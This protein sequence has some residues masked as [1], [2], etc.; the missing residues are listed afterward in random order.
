MKGFRHSRAMMLVAVA[1]LMPATGCASAGARHAMTPGGGRSPGAPGVT[2][3]IAHHAPATPEVA[4]EI[5]A[6]RKDGAA[7]REAVDA[8]T[9]MLVAN[10]APE[11]RA[12]RV[13]PA[14]VRHAR[15]QRIDPVLVVAIIGV[16]NP[17]LDLDAKSPHG[18]AV[19]VMQVWKGWKKEIHDCGG[20]DLTDP[21]VNVCFGTRVLRMALDD[22]RTLAGA[23]HRY[24]GCTHGARC[25]RYV[26]AVY[27]RAGRALLEGGSGGDLETA[28]SNA[29]PE[30]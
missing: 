16:E 15:E 10:G 25:D 27:Q 22:T 7:A 13:A 29:T 3:V 8:V 6:E 2:S 24:N 23:L 18:S 14:V 21:D 19:G 1:A 11:S 28:E 30:G 12:K 9:R 4:G 26:R 20:S 5:A 17:E